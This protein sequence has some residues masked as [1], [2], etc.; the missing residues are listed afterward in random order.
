MSIE[1]DFDPLLKV[2]DKLAVFL[3]R[4]EVQIQLISIAMVIVVTA[5]VNQLFWRFAS[6]PAQGW[7]GRRS[8]ERLQVYL[9]SGM[10][11]AKAVSFPVLGL[12][13]FGL[14]QSILVSQGR[15]DGLLEKSAWILWTLIGFEILV[16]TLYA[17]FEDDDVK[18]YHYRLLIPMLSV[19]IVLQLLGNLTDLEAASNVVV[20]HVFGSPITVGI[21]F[22][23]T[24]GLYFWTDAVRG[25]HDLVF[26]FIEKRT[27]VDPGSAKAALTLIRYALI[28][29][30]VALV[31]SRLDLSATTIA[32]ISG[33]LSVG[34]GF[35]LQ[36]I[37]SN[38]ISG[39]LLLVERSLRPGDVIEVDNELSVVQDLS[40]RA[41]TVRTLNNVE[42][43]IPNQTFFTSSFKTFT[44]SDKNVRVPIEVHTDCDIDPILVIQ[45][46]RATALAHPEVLHSPAPSVFMLEYGNN[47]ARFQLNIWIDQPL[48]SPR[49]QSQLK[50]M[51]WQAFEDHTIHLPFPEVQ[52]HF[53]ERVNLQTTNGLEKQLSATSA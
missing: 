41:T 30:G 38:F 31:M 11:L 8:S 32:A 12:V 34:I 53:P 48:E 4:P 20:G 52:L 22:F 3:S 35:S 5:L 1:S 45:V 28:I 47:V 49:I 43:V 2:F 27:R 7:I 18:R 10:S 25:F 40:V 15:L 50:V 42:L 51:I 29:F 24:I 21:V 26:Q 37:V 23:A 13:F 46:L 44:G 14:A 6:Q 9:R 17:I 19:I 39:I 16:A 33:G 36:G